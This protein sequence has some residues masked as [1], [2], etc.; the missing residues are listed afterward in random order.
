MP[1]KS[2]HS[3]AP[4]RKSGDV[5][6]SS[7]EQRQGAPERREPPEKRNPKM[8]HERDESAQ[9]TRTNADDT[10]RPPADDQI[11][12]AFDD[13]ESGQVNTDRRGIPADVPRSTRNRES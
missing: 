5:D 3:Q 7:Y 13:V 11:V 10:M 9:A 2:K 6:T 8:P 1:A 12:H 4:T